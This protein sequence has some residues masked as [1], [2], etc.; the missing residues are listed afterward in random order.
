MSKY[1]VVLERSA[2][3]YL[4][5]IVEAADQD[6]AEEIGG[7]LAPKFDSDFE[8]T[9]AHNK[10]TVVRQELSEDNESSWEVCDSWKDGE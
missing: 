2:V 4:E 7:N 10:L 3:E 1:H 6:E 8:K 5:I 9:V